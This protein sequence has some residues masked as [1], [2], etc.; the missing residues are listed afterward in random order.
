MMNNFSKR[1]PKLTV[2]ATGLIACLFLYA[3]LADADPSLIQVQG[4]TP[5]QLLKVRTAMEKAAYGPSAATAPAKED[6]CE[7]YKPPQKLR[8]LK[9][10]P[11]TDRC[12]DKGIAVI[13]DTGVAVIFLCN[14]GITVADYDF[15]LGREG[16]NKRA[17]GD[18]KTPIGKYPLGKPRPSDLFKIF[19]PIG[20]P[21]PEQIEKG[22][23]GADVGIHGPSRTF[24]CAGF[25]N[26]AV[27]W[28]QGCLAVA[29]D[30]YVKEI[31]RFIEVNGIRSITIN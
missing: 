31:A 10:M 4:A 29:S 22:F 3:G 26:V 6:A 18:L 19:I 25:L 16:V 28:T 8:F 2:A 13:A 20:F 11:T 9:R 5:T 1:L 17:L 15:S 23:S 27:D 21:T 12:K 30:I 7:F 14:N 24:R